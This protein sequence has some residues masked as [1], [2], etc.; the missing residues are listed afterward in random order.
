MAVNIARV[1]DAVPKRLDRSRVQDVRLVA[2]MCG[3]AASVDNA[4]LDANCCRD[5]AQV[6][7]RM[8]EARHYMVPERRRM[9]TTPD[10]KSLQAKV[11]D[12]I[13]GVIINRDIV[14]VGFWAV[15]AVFEASEAMDRW[16]WQIVVTRPVRL[17][18]MCTSRSSLVTFDAQ[19]EQREK[20]ERRL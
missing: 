6:W 5:L 4:L 7:G 10:R 18:T 11:F 2:S 15:D 3:D 16:R 14:L 17:D 13:A 9:R 20:P 19:S 8:H 1:G 12:S